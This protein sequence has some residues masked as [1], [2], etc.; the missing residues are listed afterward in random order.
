[1]FV[2]KTANFSWF[3]PYNIFK[4]IVYKLK[5]IY[6]LIIKAMFG[7]KKQMYTSANRQKEGMGVGGGGSICR[8]DANES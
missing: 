7:H 3:F 1:M 4:I 5:V 6:W 8:K 2:N